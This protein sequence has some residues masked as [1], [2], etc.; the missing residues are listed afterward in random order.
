MKRFP[1]LW[2]R[3]S[4]VSLKG[5]V[6]ELHVQRAPERADVISSQFH[7]PLLAANCL[8]WVW[9]LGSIPV[10]W[11]LRS[12]AVRWG[13]LSQ[14]GNRIS[15]QPLLTVLW[16]LRIYHCRMLCV[17]TLSYEWLPC[18]VSIL[19]PL[20]PVTPGGQVLCYLFLPCRP[21]HSVVHTVALLFA[22]W[23]NAMGV[24]QVLKHLSGI[25]GPGSWGGCRVVIYRNW[26]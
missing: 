1:N 5:S 14:A 23:V 8:V 12:E 6:T 22:E 20:A 2:V 3:N 11:E 9:P 17:I 19:L 4:H 18:F 15:H 21:Q 7:E 13:S 10:C 26:L 16:K 24:L 25:L